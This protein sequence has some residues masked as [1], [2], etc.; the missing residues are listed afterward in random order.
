MGLRAAGVGGVAVRKR[1]CLIL[2][3]FGGSYRDLRKTLFNVAFGL[4]QVVNYMVVALAVVAG[5]FH[6]AEEVVVA[7]SQVR[8]GRPRGG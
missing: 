1:A 7:V 5:A 8:H 4:R 2:K 6:S 3:C